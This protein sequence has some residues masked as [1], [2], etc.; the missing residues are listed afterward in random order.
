VE[1]REEAE[2]YDT[3]DKPTLVRTHHDKT[4]TNDVEQPAHQG[5]VLLGEL[6]LEIS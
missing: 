2:D 4:E 6:V 3:L 1:R 5:E